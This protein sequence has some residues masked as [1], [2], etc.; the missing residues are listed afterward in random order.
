MS[1]AQVGGE[2]G[3]EPQRREEQM[4]DGTRTTWRSPRMPRPCRVIGLLL[5]A[6]SA[7]AV[8]GPAGAQDSAEL[9]ELY[10]ADQAD[11]RHESPPGPEVWAAIS[12]RD[13]LRGARVLEILR[14]ASVRTGADFYHAAMVL[15]HGQGSE[16]ILLAHILATSAALLGDDRGRWL[17]AASLDRYLHRTRAPQ[18]FGTQY[19]KS[20][21]ADPYVLDSSQPWSQGSYVDWLPDSVRG[22]FGVMSRTEQ[23]DRLRAMNGGDGGPQPIPPGS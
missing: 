19:L 6:G 8:P 22:I 13:A 11:R 16:D 14:S 15:Q 4:D 2:D 23:A 17:S 21:E 9:R 10:E 12:R 5:A 18:R 20:S 1:P 7:L 3:G